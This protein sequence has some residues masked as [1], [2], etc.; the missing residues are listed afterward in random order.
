MEITRR[1]LTKGAAWVA[2][3][4]VTSAAVPAYAASNTTCP[5]LTSDSVAVSRREDGSTV[6]NLNL[7]FINT[8]ES[9]TMTLS[10]PTGTLELPADFPFVDEYSFSADNK[11]MTW[12]N[13]YSL[14]ENYMNVNLVLQKDEVVVLTYKGE[15]GCSGEYVYVPAPETCPSSVT[16]AGTHNNGSVISYDD[17]QMVS[18]STLSMPDDGIITVM[19]AEF[20]QARIDTSMWSVVD[21]NTLK[22]IGTKDAAVDVSIPLIIPELP[23]IAENPANKLNS[24]ESENWTSTCTVYGQASDGYSCTVSANDYIDQIVIHPVGN[25]SFTFSSSSCRMSESAEILIDPTKQPS[26]T[27]FEVTNLQKTADSISFNYTGYLYGLVIYTDAK[28]AKPITDAPAGFEGRMGLDG[29]FLY[30]LDKTFV[31]NKLITVPLSGGSTVPHVTIG[32]FVIRDGVLSMRTGDS[33]Y[34]PYNP[35]D[36]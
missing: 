13:L 34:S 4:L 28:D 24:Y 18:F 3:V 30:S 10:T 22:Y 21:A 17:G 32:K 7:N 23:M 16:F 36:A 12:S 20:D 1:S 2:P 25:A 11:T 9:A 26:Q 8:G 31:E 14:T 33:A 5:E 29:A 19:N 6:V 15:G 27:T 35:F